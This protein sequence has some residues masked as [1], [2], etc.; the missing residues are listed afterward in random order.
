MFRHSWAPPESD[1]ETPVKPTEKPLQ[2]LV[3]TIPLTLSVV[4]S[5]V[6]QPVRTRYNPV[7][8]NRQEKTR[9]LEI[10]SKLDIEGMFVK[11]KEED[12]GKLEVERELEE[13]R[14]SRARATPIN[15]RWQ[16]A[17]KAAERSKSALP[18][19]RL[20]LPDDCWVVERPPSRLEE[21]REKMVLELETVKQ[22]R[23]DCLA[24]P[25]LERPSPR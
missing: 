21:E 25:E 9:S 16:P 12:A 22:A 7:E 3:S 10:P 17:E 4:F 8:V 24:A 2:S 1:S 14:E 19:G 18:I 13:V 23:S 5:G 15:K 20:H 11:S 6:Q